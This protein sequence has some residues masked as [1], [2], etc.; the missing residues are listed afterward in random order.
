MEKG[1]IGFFY[2]ISYLGR[3]GGFYGIIS[4]EFFFGYRV[5]EEIVG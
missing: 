3:F 2:V 4:I 1:G 5:E